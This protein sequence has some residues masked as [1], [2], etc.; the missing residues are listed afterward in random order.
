MCATDTQYVVQLSGYDWALQ[1][2]AGAARLR[3]LDAACGVGYGTDVLARA[4]AT[5]VG[6]DV[7]PDALRE[8][9]CRFGAPNLAFCLMDVTA[10]AFRANAF[11]AVVS[12][13]TIEHVRDDDRFVAEVARVLV[14]GGTFVVF[15]PYREV[16]T[17]TPDNPY[18]VR[19]YSPETLSHLLHPHFREVRL[20]GR[21][22][23]PALRRVEATLDEVRGHDPLS[24]RRLVPRRLRHRLASAWLTARGA[25]TLAQVSVVDLEYVPSAGPGSDTVV[26]VCR[27]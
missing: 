23:G 1:R 12:Q 16:H 19:E 6:V 21:R 18:H 24:L 13:D 2:L 10:L 22:P 9:H 8:A 11:D 26:A 7:A 3:V 14:P 4:V 27:R 20:F 15:T 17:A 5:A 25:K